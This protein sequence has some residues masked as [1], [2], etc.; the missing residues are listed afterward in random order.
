MYKILYQKGG[1]YDFKHSYED[2]TDTFFKTTYGAFIQ[3]YPFAGLETLSRINF[4]ILHSEGDTFDSFKAFFYQF[5]LLFLEFFQHFLKNKDIILLV[6]ISKKLEDGKEYDFD[7]DSSN[8]TD[9]QI[10]NVNDETWF[11]IHKEFRTYNY[12]FYNYVL[13][14][15]SGFTAF[16]DLK[17]KAGIKTPVTEESL[18]FLIKLKEINLLK[19]VERSELKY[20]LAAYCKLKIILEKQDK[21]QYKDYDVGKL[22]DLTDYISSYIEIRAKQITSI[23]EQNIRNYKLIISDMDKFYNLFNDPYKDLDEIQQKLIIRIYEVYNLVK[24]LYDDENVSLLR[25]F[26]LI[27]NLNLVIINLDKI[28][29][30]FV[31]GGLTSGI[32]SKN[33][34]YYN[35]LKCNS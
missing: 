21:G 17:K 30:S 5:H 11:K 20:F 4:A 25:N 14:Q 32:L 23:I 2:E 13:Y 9:E 18:N 6:T 3:K 33:K 19:L 29:G 24:Q 1:L 8:W 22:N 28:I 16:D 26:Q 12:K 7:Y 27:S 15:D 31:H 10:Y 35:I 34:I